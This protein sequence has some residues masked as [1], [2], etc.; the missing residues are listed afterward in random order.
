MTVKEAIEARR[1]IRR[2]TDQPVS[3]ELLLELI[4]AARLSPSGCN[5]QPWR[6]RLVTDRADIEWF[7]GEATSKQGWIAKA[8]AVIVCCVDT[9]AYMKDSRATIRALQEAGMVTDE[10]AGEVENLYLRPAECG[11]PELLK[12]AAGLNLAIAMTSMMYRAV[13]LGLGSTWVGR[14]DDAATRGRL[15]IPDGLAVMALLP[16]G[17]P[18]ESPASRPRKGIEEILV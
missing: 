17:F 8:G 18:A 9:R 14:V 5:S 4:E 13:E 3:R 16:V 10:F 1:S 6:F 2:F 15:G 11:P 7:A 12:G